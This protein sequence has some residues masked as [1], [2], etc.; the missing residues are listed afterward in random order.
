MAFDMFL[1]EII[2]EIPRMN[3]TKSDAGVDLIMSREAVDIQREFWRIDVGDVQ[4]GIILTILLITGKSNPAS[5]TQMRYPN[6][7]L[8]SKKP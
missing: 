5:L 3:W 8:V 2:F 1:Q 4:T 6:A 7:F